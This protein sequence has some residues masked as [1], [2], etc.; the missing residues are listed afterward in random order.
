MKKNFVDDLSY[1]F[2]IPDI[3]KNDISIMLSK[4]FERF[5]EIRPIF[6]KTDLSKLDDFSVIVNIHADYGLGTYIIHNNWLNDPFLISDDYSVSF[7][8]AEYNE[9]KKK[10]KL[11]EEYVLKDVLEKFKDN[12]KCK[13][14]IENDYKLLKTKWHIITFDDK[15]IGLISENDSWRLICKGDSYKKTK[16]SNLEEGLEYLKAFNL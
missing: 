11:T 2:D 14:Y 12:K 13:W 4:N 3:Y 5:F 10:K 15:A 8:I 1:M 7:S 6:Y 9:M 16:I